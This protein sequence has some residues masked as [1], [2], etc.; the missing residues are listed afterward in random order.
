MTSTKRITEAQITAGAKDLA[1]QITP[2]NHSDGP[3]YLFGPPSTPT[4]EDCRSCGGPI[5]PRHGAFYRL[6]AGGPGWENA[7][8]HGRCARLV[9]AL[10]EMDLITP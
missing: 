5:T 6:M 3:W 4:V 10:S 1:A 8:L 9:A 7:V 2:E